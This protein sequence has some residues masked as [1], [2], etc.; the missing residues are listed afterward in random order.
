M[1][2]KITFIFKGGNREKV[3][4]GFE[5][6]FSDKGWKIEVDRQKR[7]TV[8][9]LPEAPTGAFKEFKI[10]LLVTK[11]ALMLIGVSMDMQCE[12]EK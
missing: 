9:V 6:E 1:T 11:P 8:L 12:V 4:F 3:V 2:E 5:K 7:K 10:R